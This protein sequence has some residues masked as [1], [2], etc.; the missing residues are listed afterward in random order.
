MRS[1]FIGG[2]ICSQPV[3]FDVRN[4]GGAG[5]GSETGVC[6]GESAR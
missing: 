1:D 6:F 2:L 4:G 5:V 3:T